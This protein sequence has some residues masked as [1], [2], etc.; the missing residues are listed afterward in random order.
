VDHRNHLITGE[1][2]DAIGNIGGVLDIR[3]LHAI[4][5]LNSP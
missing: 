3:G 1:R 2:R 4:D 5:K